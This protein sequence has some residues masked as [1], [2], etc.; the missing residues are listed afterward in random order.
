MEHFEEQQ[1]PFDFDNTKIIDKQTIYKK[2][3]LSE[4]VHIQKEKRSINK[5]QDI[6]KLSSSYFNIINFT[7]NQYI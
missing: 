5:K 3:L 2:R 6:E 4:M 1:H 7:T